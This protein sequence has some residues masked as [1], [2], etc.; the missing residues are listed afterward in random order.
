MSLANTLMRKPSLPDSRRTHWIRLPHSP[1]ADTNC[2][3]TSRNSGTPVSHASSYRDAQVSIFA[4]R[5]HSHAP[6]HAPSIFS[7]RRG[8]VER[9]RLD[10]PHITPHLV[11]GKPAPKPQKPKP[12][13]YSLAPAVKASHSK[14]GL[15]T[16]NSLFIKRLL[17]PDFSSG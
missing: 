2:A 5:A 14:V 15:K 4:S 6:S 16:L 17:Q 10:L 1:L 9:R 13:N 11:L 7:S 8:S 3:E 12:R